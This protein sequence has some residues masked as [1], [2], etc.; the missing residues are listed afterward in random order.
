L[1]EVAGNGDQ[2]VEP[3]S[4]QALREEDL[5]ADHNEDIDDIIG[6]APPQG[7]ARQVLTQELNAVHSDEP[8]SFDEAEQD[9][10]WRRAM[11]RRNEVN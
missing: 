10:S 11:L 5:D 6:P 4:P 3:A 2:A 9:P 7:L 1:V 8:N